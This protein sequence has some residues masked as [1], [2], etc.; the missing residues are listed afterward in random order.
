MRPLGLHRFA[1]GHRDSLHVHAEIG[2]PRHR[3]TLA[4][5]SPASKLY[6]PNVGGQSMIA[7]PGAR[8]K[9]AEQIDQLVGALPGRMFAA[10]TPVYSARA[11]RSSR[12]SGSG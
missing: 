5:A 6:M 4:P 12:C 2:P 10:G 3:I 8:D 11:A 9:P 1:I 7:S